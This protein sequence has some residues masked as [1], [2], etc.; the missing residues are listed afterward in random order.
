M[1]DESSRYQSH[2][3][4]MDNYVS[5]QYF[6]YL[7][8]YSQIDNVCEQY[9]VTN[10]VTRSMIHRCISHM[11]MHY[12]VNS[13]NRVYWHAYGQT[14]PI[15]IKVIRIRTCLLICRYG[16]ETRQLSFHDYQMWSFTCNRLWYVDALAKGTYVRLH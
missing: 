10:N 8:A 16:P 9:G 1:V 11:S 14:G 13:Q 3:Y 12:N 7:R 15:A 5:S 4:D 6:V 2:A